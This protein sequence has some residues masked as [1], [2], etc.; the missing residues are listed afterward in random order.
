MYRLMKEENGR[1][2]VGSAAMMLGIRLSANELPVDPHGNV[3][4]STGGMSVYASLRVIPARMVP[5]R[6]KSL[7][8]FAAGNNNLFVWA[9]GEGPFDPGPVAA[10]LRLRIDADDPFHGFIEPDAIM[11]LQEYLDA[12]AATKE[13][14][15]VDES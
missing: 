11:S 15:S 3:H 5:K 1:P 2:K 9:M 4:P 8:Q 14:W 10:R 6:L 13:L 7:V 12:L